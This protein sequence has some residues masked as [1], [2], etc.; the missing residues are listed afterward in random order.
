MAMPAQKWPLLSQH[1]LFVFTLVI[2]RSVASSLCKATELSYCLTLHS[3]KPKA[4]LKNGQELGKKGI[5]K[6]FP[7]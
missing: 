5:T 7:R 2:D 3:V 6:S 1:V 4:G